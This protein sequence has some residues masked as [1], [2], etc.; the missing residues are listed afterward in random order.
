MVVLNV[1][2]TEEEFDEFLSLLEKQRNF[3]KFKILELKTLREASTTF[4]GALDYKEREDKYVLK[5]NLLSKIINSLLE[6]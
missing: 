2:F 5:F 1:D 3:Y 6:V 4:E